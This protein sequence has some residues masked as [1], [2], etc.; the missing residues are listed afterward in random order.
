[1]KAILLE[2]THAGVMRRATVEVTGRTLE[3]HETHRVHVL[4]KHPLTPMKRRFKY[5][6]L[7]ER[8]MPSAADLV[9]SGA[10]GHVIGLAHE[11][12]LMVETGGEDDEATLDL[13]GS[14]F[15][16]RVEKRRTGEDDRTQDADKIM[17]MMSKIALFGVMALLLMIGLT[18]G[19]QAFRQL[20]ASFSAG[21]G[22]G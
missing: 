13:V 2:M 12:S 20:I 21:A 8:W 9:P 22:V 11:G 6:K 19:P 15:A 7:I 14:E 10:A 4:G 17:L 1:M 3:D 16:I 5:Y 18:F